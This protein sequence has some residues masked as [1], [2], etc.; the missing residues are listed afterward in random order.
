M[1]LHTSYMAKCT[2]QPFQTGVHAN[3]CLDQCNA[4]SHFIMQS[5]LAVVTLF[6][7]RTCSMK[8]MRASFAWLLA[9][10]RE[11]LF[12]DSRASVKRTAV[13]GAQ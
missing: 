6:L 3:S 12:D 4:R 8:G 7:N 11:I 1:P 5:M 9:R 2:Q 13:V 10:L